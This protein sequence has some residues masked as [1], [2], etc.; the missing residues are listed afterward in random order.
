MTET[1]YRKKLPG[2][3]RIIGQYITE[4]ADD[5]AALPEGTQAYTLTIDLNPGD[6]DHIFE[7]SITAER[8]NVVLPAL[9]YYY[10]LDG[11]SLGE[12]PEDMEAE[13]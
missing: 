6:G 10:D 13:G 12:L 9:R 1:R 3:L 4:H 8:K 11:V 7:P 5:L 2:V